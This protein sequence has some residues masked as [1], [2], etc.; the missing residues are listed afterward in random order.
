LSLLVLV[1]GLFILNFVSAQFFGSNS[2]SITSF[3][4]SVNPQDMTFLAL[5][6]ILFALIFFILSKA[7]FFRD[8]YGNPNRAVIGV[9]AIAVSLLSTYY[10]YTSGFDLQGM[11]SGF[12]VSSDIFYP[13]F[14]VI[15]VVAAIFMIMY[16]GFRGFFIISG[17]LLILVALFTNLIYSEGIAIIVGIILLALGLWM[18]R[19]SKNAM[20]SGGRAF[21]GQVRKDYPAASAGWLWVL[22][23]GLVLVVGFALSNGIV[24]IIGFI[25]TVVTLWI[26]FRGPK[27]QQSGYLEPHPV[28]I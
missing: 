2:F 10:L 21:G 16:M 12:G 26:K 14:A 7:R 17:I 18:G 28:N 25:L 15:L 1:S 5:F 27:P 3:F 13:V 22:L 9:I 6:F 24:M 8:A 20:I 19:G 11:F 4:N 23:S